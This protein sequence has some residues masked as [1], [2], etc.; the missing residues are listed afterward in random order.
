MLNSATA[1]I[2]PLR[3]LTV[4]VSGMLP[5]FQLDLVEEGVL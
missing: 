5:Y 2:L 4:V 1:L 3:E